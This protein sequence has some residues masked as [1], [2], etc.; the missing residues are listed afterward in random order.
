M[1]EQELIKSN[2]SKVKS[3]KQQIA[4]QEKLSRC[5]TNFSREDA[6]K[7]LVKRSEGTYL[8]RPS[9]TGDYALSIV[10]DGFVNHAVIKYVDGHFG[11]ASPY[12]FE[13][14]GELIEFYE[15]RS[16]GRHNCE[17]DVVLKTPFRSKPPSFV[18]HIK[19]LF[20][21]DIVKRND[22]K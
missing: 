9:S 12:P 19:K 21:V 17:L 14:L 22:K 2:S 4:L 16:L 15:R 10:H 8:I 20:S 5:L 18:K 1:K 7:A 6:H 3:V 11:F 13:S